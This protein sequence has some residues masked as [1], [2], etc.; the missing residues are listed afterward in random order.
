MSASMVHLVLWVT[1]ALIGA[2]IVLYVKTPSSSC[3]QE[4]EEKVEKSEKTNSDKK[5]EKVENTQKI[6][7]TNNQEKTEKIVVDEKK[8]EK[9]ARVPGE[10]VV[11]YIF[12]ATG[13]VMAITSWVVEQGGDV[14]YVGLSLLLSLMIFC[15]GLGGICGVVCHA[16]LPSDQLEGVAKAVC[17]LTGL[18]VISILALIRGG[19]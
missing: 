7:K 6:E 9:N 19:M 5:N 11:M 1:M 10:N 12:A 13:V 4:T 18:V 8:E 15:L 2:S 3:M 16:Y 14:S 17:A